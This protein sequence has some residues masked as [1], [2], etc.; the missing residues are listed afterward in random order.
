MYSNC[1][2]NLKAFAHKKNFQQPLKFF[3]IDV[4]LVKTTLY[5]HVQGYEWHTYSYYT[6]FFVCNYSYSNR[7]QLQITGALT[8]QS[9]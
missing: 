9:K 8:M 7:L 2:Y 1:L 4:K 3:F 5:V 6:W